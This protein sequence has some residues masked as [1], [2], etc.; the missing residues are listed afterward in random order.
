MFEIK[1]NEKNKSAVIL[2]PEAGVKISGASVESV[3]N[4]GV[5][6]QCYSAKRDLYGHSLRST[7]KMTAFAL[8]L[9][10]NISTAFADSCKSGEKVCGTGC[11]AES[12]ECKSCGGSCYYT[13]TTDGAVTLYGSGEVASRNVYEWKNVGG[14]NGYYSGDTADTKHPFYANPNI[15]SVSFDS[16]SNFTK[17]GNSAFSNASGLT[18]ITLPNTVTRI[19]DQ[20]F[21]G[22]SSLTSITIPEGVT[23]IGINTFN[24]ASGLTSITLPDSLTSIGSSAF[25]NASSL[26]SITIPEGVTGIGDNVFYNATGLTSIT[27]PEGVTGIGEGAFHD[28]S[29]LESIIIPDNINTEGWNSRVFRELPEGVNIVCQGGLNTCYEKLAKYF[30]ADDPRCPAN[31]TCNC[32]SGCIDSSRISEA[33]S[34]SQCSGNYGWSGAGCSRKNTDGSVPCASGFVEWDKQCWSE[35]PFAKKRWTP[36]EA[37]EWLHDGNDNFVVI[38][39]KK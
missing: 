33:T 35:Y 4:D 15:T 34:P 30:S 39:F 19:G 21:Y 12:M 29:G 18:S 28:A 25:L 23:S 1:K 8:L 20:A 11:I 10:L 5:K 2:N 26:T 6:T 32:S 3:V 13:Q 22:A 17:I 24:S 9:S 16:S 27:I 31:A 7:L 14:V 38:T 36:A 37:A